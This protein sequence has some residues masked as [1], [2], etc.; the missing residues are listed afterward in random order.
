MFRMLLNSFVL[1]TA[2][3]KQRGQEY[4]QQFLDYTMSVAE[5]IIYKYSPGGRKIMDDQQHGGLPPF[6]LEHAHDPVHGLI[7]I[8]RKPGGPRNPQKVCAQC[9]FEGKDRKD[10]RWYCPACN[11]GLCSWACYEAYHMTSPTEL[12]KNVVK[13]KTAKRQQR[14]Q[15]QFT[16]VGL[17]QQH[18]Y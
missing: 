13:K 16:E 10:T 1:Y 15:Q 11:A 9:S 12:L 3:Q 7:K 2:Q 8:P 18:L 4:K 6:Q 14:R 17:I 5:Q